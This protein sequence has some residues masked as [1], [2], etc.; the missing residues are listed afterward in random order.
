MWRNY[1]KTRLFRF[2]RFQVGVKINEEYKEKKECKTVY[3]WRLCEAIRSKQRDHH[4]LIRNFAF[5][6]KCENVCRHC[7]WQ[8]QR[9]TGE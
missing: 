6:S 7:N 9:A 8:L 2:T 5:S 4:H 3:A 1:E